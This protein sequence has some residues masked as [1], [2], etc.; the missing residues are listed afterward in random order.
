MCKIFQD[1]IEVL[2][3][4]EEAAELLEQQIMEYRHE[5]EIQT[6]LKELNVMKARISK[7]LTQARQGL[8]TIEVSKVIVLPL[9]K[10]F[11]CSEYKHFIFVTLY[12]NM[13]H[14]I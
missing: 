7:L 11:L 3:K 8:L 13:L 12:N 5:A 1:G 10:T 4:C 14:N 6:L 2:V 9:L